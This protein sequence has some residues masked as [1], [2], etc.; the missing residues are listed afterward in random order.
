MG[1]MKKGP[2]AGG[3][4]LGLR[5]A[6]FEAKGATPRFRREGTGETAKFVN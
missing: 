4:A 1:E 5:F 3:A 6:T 2:S